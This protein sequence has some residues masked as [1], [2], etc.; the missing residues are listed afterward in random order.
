MRPP[1]ILLYLLLSSICRLAAQEGNSGIVTDVRDGRDYKWVKIGTQTW[2]AENLAY[3]PTVSPSTTFSAFQPYYHIYEY[4]GTDLKEARN[5]NYHRYGVLYN[6]EAA[7]NACPP[8]WHLPTDPEWKVLEKYLGMDASEAD[9]D[10]IRESGNAGLKLKSRSGWTLKTANGNNGSGFNALPG[11]YKY[12][13]GGYYSKGYEAHFWTA[14]PDQTV[15]S[16][17]RTLYYASDGVR[18]SNQLRIYGYSVR[19]I[20]N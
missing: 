16:W 13:I 9:K 2:M 20:R 19:C 17:N 3:L 4:E 11:G 15:R 6:W 5:G 14:T 10:D 8:G 1:L 18:R 7:N 12:Q